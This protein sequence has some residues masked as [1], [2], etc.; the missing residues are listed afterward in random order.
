MSSFETRYPTLARWMK[1]QGW[2]EVGDIDG[3][4]AMIQVLDMGGMIWEGDPSYASFEDAFRA[5]DEAVARFW[6]EQ[7]GEPQWTESPG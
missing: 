5:A 4:R 1:F 7:G 3:S 2:I 6:R